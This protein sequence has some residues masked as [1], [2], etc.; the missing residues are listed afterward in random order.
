[1][2]AV[3]LIAQDH[4]NIRNLFQRFNDV[5]PEAYDAKQRAADEIVR[6]LV[7]HAEVKQEVFYPEVRKVA[8]EIG[9]QFDDDLEGNLLVEGLVTEVG[10]V[11]SDDERFANVKVLEELI[12]RHLE[13]EEDELLPRVREVMSDETL[14]QLGERMLALKKTK[15][16][17]AKRSDAT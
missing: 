7:A 2:D 10:A 12:T 3:E 9:S 5:G 16:A 14:E 15:R 8:P 4:D 11:A 13:H 1:M 17:G 6:E